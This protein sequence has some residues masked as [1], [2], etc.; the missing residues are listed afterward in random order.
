MNFIANNFVLIVVMV[1]LFLFFL[2]LLVGGISLK[3]GIPWKKIMDR[4]L[5]C[6][7]ITGVYLGVGLM[8]IDLSSAHQSKID[9]SVF[10]PNCITIFLIAGILTI[11]WVTI[12]KAL[13]KWVLRYPIKP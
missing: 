12:I 3:K 10:V 13:N 8:L 9:F 1:T 11:F 6:N 4:I 5:I 2:P 7:C